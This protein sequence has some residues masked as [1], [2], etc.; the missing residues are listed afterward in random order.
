[1]PL[2]SSSRRHIRLSRG[3]PSR[4][5]DVASVN[6]YTKPKKIG[7]KSAR[8]QKKKPSTLFLKTLHPF[9]PVKLKPPAPPLKVPLDTNMS[10][11]SLDDTMNF[12]IYV[13][14]RN[15]LDDTLSIPIVT[16]LVLAIPLLL[17]LGILCSLLLYVGQVIWL[18]IAAACYSMASS[19]KS[20]ANVPTEAPLSPR[21]RQLAWAAFAKHTIATRPDAFE[22]VKRFGEKLKLIKGI[23]EEDTTA[24][25]AF[26]ADWM[27]KQ[28]QLQHA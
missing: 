3:P 1:M 26:V 15:M 17:P 4:A 5:A 10:I 18:S 24:Y 7:G 16:V 6:K 8:N 19:F 23:R 20:N 21:E 22:G 14:V 9:H 25:E 27:Q 12:R 2:C 28:K 11:N 13:K